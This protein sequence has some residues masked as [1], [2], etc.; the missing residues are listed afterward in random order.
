M[1]TRLLPSP[2]PHIARCIGNIGLVHEANRNLDRA[3]EY[4]FQEFEMEEQCLPPDH[5][6]L[7]MHLDWIITMYREKGEWER[8]LRFFR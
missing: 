8:I 4:F 1:Y 7:S 2:H 3:L 5:P 6:N